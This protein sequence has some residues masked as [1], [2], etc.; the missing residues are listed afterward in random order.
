M[1]QVHVVQRLSPGGIEQLV[2]SLARRADIAV[3][4]L[5][6]SVDALCR[7]WP[8]LDEFR[9]RITGFDKQPGSAGGLAMRV[10]ARLRELSA[11][12]VVT[13]HVGPL[14]Y[15][16][17]GARLAGVRRLA[18]VEHDAWHLEAPKRRML[19]SAALRLIRPKRLAVSNLVARAASARTGLAF[20]IVENGVD[21]D[22]FRPADKAAARAAL[23]LPQD[24]FIIG[25]AGRL[26]TVKGFDILVEAAR[27]LPDDMLVA[28]WGG[29]SQREALATQITAADLGDKVL[30]AGPSS[31]MPA[32]FPALDLFCLPSR[33]EGLPLAIL[34]AQACGAPVV[35]RDVG[36]VSEG[37][38]PVTGTLVRA[39]DGEAPAALA[40]AI[41]AARDANSRGDPRQF[42][43][44]G[45]SLDATLASYLELEGKNHA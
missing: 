42:V 23:G 26:E 15:G 2:L 30:L 18:H 11:T 13:H 12:S 20:G 21:C 32:I 4:S 45:K 8:A 31:S 6:G 25:G 17:A 9:G 29:G 43:L 1:T 27:H 36:G 10:A 22:R 39:S 33:H 40:A 34:E 41:L 7:A 14:L 16:G 24:R 44:R 28:I 35:A 38:C 3:F 37:V 19:V 5:E